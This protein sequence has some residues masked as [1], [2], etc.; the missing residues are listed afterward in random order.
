M[1]HKPTGYGRTKKGYYKI[2]NPEKYLGNVNDIV[3]RS[4]WE[5]KFMLYCDMNDKITKWVSESIKITYIDYKG[6]TRYYV[7]DFYLEIKKGDYIKKLLIE[8]KPKYQTVEPK[9]PKGTISEKKLKKLKFDLANWQKNKYKWI[10][11]I[12][13]CKKRDIEFKIVTEEQLKYI[14]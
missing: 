7:P 8:V 10:H 4:S 11:A 2:K 9:I 1:A 12:E 14:K 5:L 13:W 6:K 3:Y